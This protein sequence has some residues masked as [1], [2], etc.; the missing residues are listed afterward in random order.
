MRDLNEIYKPRL[1]LPI[2]GK[3]YEIPEP[4]AEEGA[5][6]P[7]LVS[8]NI[9]L[10][11]MTDEALRYLTPP[12]VEQM[13]RDGVKWTEIQHAGRTAMVFFGHSPEMGRLYWQSASLASALPAE[14]IEHL[15]E[16]TMP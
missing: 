6:L 3:D 16:K 2:G 4:S 1:R 8:T 13:V 14:L 11:Q 9:G 12:V 7:D 10:L 15:S 5:R